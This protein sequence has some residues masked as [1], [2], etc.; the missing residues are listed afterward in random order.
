MLVLAGGLTGSSCL[1][2]QLSWQFEVWARERKVCGR[3]T[4][5]T[6]RCFGRWY[7]LWNR[8][9]QQIH[10]CGNR[11]DWKNHPRDPSAYGSKYTVV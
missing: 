2:S 11:H 8:L 3:A 6:R 9:Q 4:E 10:P 1:A 5:D 7:I